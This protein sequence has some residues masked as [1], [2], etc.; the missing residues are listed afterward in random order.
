[1]SHHNDEKLIADEEYIAQEKGDA[2]K[3]LREDLTQCRTEKEEYLTGWQRA[4]AEFINAKHTWEEERAAITRHTEQNVLTKFLAIAETFERAFK[5]VEDT[6]AHVQGFR[7][8][9]AKLDSLFASYG[10]TRISALHMPFDV[11]QHEALGTISVTDISQDGIVLEELETG[12]MRD[13]IVLKPSRV[14]IGIYS[15]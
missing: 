11:T 12:Y 13:G 10:I 14:R 6:N 15:K 4:R 3:K 8:I 5:D 7:Q 1:M 2:L 9:Y